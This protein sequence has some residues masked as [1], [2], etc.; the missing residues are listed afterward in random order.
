MPASPYKSIVQ[1]LKSEGFESPYLDRLAE[2]VDAEEEELRLEVEIRREVASALGRT[3]A[4]VDRAFLELDRARVA[5]ETAASGPE[6]DAALAWYRTARA[7]AEAARLDLRIHREA[8][9]IRRN[10][11]LSRLY[12]LP[13]RL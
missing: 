9:G 6:R 5:M 12:P 10:D 11:D 8:V 4:K 13:P 7:E 3:G 2:R 1:K